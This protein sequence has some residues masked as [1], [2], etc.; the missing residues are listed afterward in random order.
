MEL[1]EDNEGNLVVI[2]FLSVVVDSRRV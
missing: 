1:V 2:D